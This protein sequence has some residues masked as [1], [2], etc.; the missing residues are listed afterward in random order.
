MMRADGSFHTDDGFMPVGGMGEIYI[1]HS[2]DSGLSWTKA[3]GTGVFGQ[4]A[5][6]S[7]LKSGELLATYGYRKKPYGIRCC[8]SYDFGETWDLKNE[9]VI[10]D[11]APTWDCGYPFTVQ[12]PNNE[13]LTVYYNTGH[14]GTR[15]IEGMHWS[16][17]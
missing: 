1:S 10:S 3:R 9:I 8:L 14:D 7:K 15:F 13:L 11:E 4:P 16:L 12:K 5:A 2:Y 6:I 17:S